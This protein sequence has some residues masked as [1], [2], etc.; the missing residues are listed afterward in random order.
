MARNID[1]ALLRA[2]VTVAE[3]GGMTR[4]GQ[5]LNLTQAAVSQQVKRLE[6][7]FQLSLFERAKKAVVL[8]ADGDRLLPMAQRMLDM[9]DQ[10]WGTMTAPDIAGEVRVGVPHDIVRAFMPPI[11]KSFDRAWPRVSM[12]VVPGPSL[13]L[14]EQMRAGEIDLAMTTEQMVQPGG[15]VLMRDPLVWVG[16]A[17]GQ[18]HLAEPLPITLGNPKCIFRAACLSALANADLAWRAV[19]D[20][21]NMLAVYSALEADLAVT[22]LLASTVPDGLVV[23]G[24]EAGLPELPPF[25]INLYLPKSGDNEVGEEFATHIRNH[26]RAR[27][28]HAA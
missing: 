22:A 15:E 25:C 13:D 9:N 21:G 5:M 12:T 14:L 26:F 6:E 2:F 24:P 20:N 3:T 16:G 1:T 7:Q 4:A 19:V 18:A 23:L 17:D 28:R 10:V 8:T 11:L 27:Y